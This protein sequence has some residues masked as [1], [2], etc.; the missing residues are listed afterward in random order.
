MCQLPRD[1][2]SPRSTMRESTASRM[3]FVSLAERI[4]I[5]ASTGVPRERANTCTFH[6]WP[7]FAANCQVWVS[8]GLSR[9]PFNATGRV[10]GVLGVPVQSTFGYGDTRSTLGE[11]GLSATEPAK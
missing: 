6:A 11:G 10:A 2:G 4:Q 5:F 3:C 8:P 1:E 9:M 7:F